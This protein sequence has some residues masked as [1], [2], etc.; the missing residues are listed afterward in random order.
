MELEIYYIAYLTISYIVIFISTNIP[1]FKTKKQ[2]PGCVKSFNG[3]PVNDKSD[4]TLV[5]YISCVIFNI[6][7]KSYPWKIFTNKSLHSNKI[8]TQTIISDKLEHFIEKY[9]LEKPFVQS[10]ITNKINNLYKDVDDK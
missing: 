7:I 2:F 10:K 4:N 9:L 8:I 1:S 6:K 3:W 5:E